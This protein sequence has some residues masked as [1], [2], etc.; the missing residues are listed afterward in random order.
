MKLNRI[1]LV[2]VIMSV[3][4]GI[5]MATMV[6]DTGFGL[7]GS[8]YQN[9]EVPDID[10]GDITTRSWYDVGMAFYGNIGWGFGKS[11]FFS[12]RMEL[13]AAVGGLRPEQHYIIA[14][15]GQLRLVASINP[16][17]ST[18][19]SV[20]GGFAESFLISWKGDT[21]NFNGWV[22]GARI[23]YNIFFLDYSVILDTTGLINLNMPESMNL[24]NKHELTLGISLMPLMG[25]D[26]RNKS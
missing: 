19:F 3:F 26:K 14:P 20:F 1:V 24:Q 25:K 21:V 22:V 18:Y 17:P 7:Y 2:L 11:E 13:F 16:F 6:G 5:A 4:S 12:L 15:S 10:S 9:A 8:F 23:Q